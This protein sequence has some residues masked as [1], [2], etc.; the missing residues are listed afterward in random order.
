MNYKKFYFV[1]C[2]IVIPFSFGVSRY[3]DA[4]WLKH[5]EQD[6]SLLYVESYVSSTVREKQAQALK[7]AGTSERKPAF[8]LPS[9]AIKKAEYVCKLHI[10][11]V[12]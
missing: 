1:T 10:L 7:A 6:G 11:L 12:K 8:S 2:I 3:E 9:K 4:E 5:V